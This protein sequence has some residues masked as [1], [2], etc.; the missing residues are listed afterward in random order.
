MNWN[1][2]KWT[3]KSHLTK[4]V[5]YEREDVKVYHVQFCQVYHVVVMSYIE[6]VHVQIGAQFIYFKRLIY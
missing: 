3:H 2:S 6:C 1:E 5:E 4:V